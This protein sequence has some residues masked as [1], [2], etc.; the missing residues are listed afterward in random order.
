MGQT[1]LLPFLRKAAE[2][3]SALKNPTASAGFEPAT[4]RPPKPLFG[5]V[6][7]QY[8][9]PSW[10]ILSKRSKTFVRNVGKFLPESKMSHR[11]NFNSR[12]ADDSIS[13]TNI[14]IFLYYL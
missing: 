7:T 13:Y 3:F 5:D 6:T 1:A 4:S 10:F 12:S 11:I 2:D 14:Y 9:S 8:T